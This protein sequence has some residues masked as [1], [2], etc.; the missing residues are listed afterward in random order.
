VTRVPLVPDD[1]ADDV[2]A[3]VLEVFRTEGREPIAL[4]RALANVPA[5][6]RSYSVFARSLRTDATSDRRLRELVILRTAQLTASAYEWSH[7]VPMATAAGLRREQIDALETW[8]TSSAFDESERAV[9]RCAEKVHVLG[10]S[11]ETFAELERLLGRTGALEM[12]LT[13][14]FYEAV[15]RIVQA[16]G[17]EVEPAYASHL[18]DFEPRGEK[19]P[20]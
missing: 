4:Y 18:D 11:D 19:E 5:L 20:Q 15:A 13:A 8:E 10:V 12:V 2:T 1:A 6:L 14:S 3:S 16:L 9:L 7:H 17:V